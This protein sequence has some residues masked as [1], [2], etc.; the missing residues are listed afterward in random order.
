[1]ITHD[2]KYAARRAGRV[3]GIPRERQRVAVV[4]RLARALGAGA[5]S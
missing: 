4:A 5:N 3:A 2:R 1:M